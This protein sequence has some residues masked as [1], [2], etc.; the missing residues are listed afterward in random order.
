[1]L[2]KC[3]GG[4]AG[5]AMVGPLIVWGGLNAIGFTAG[6]VAAGTRQNTGIHSFTYT[7]T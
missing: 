2:L 4:I 6:G 1:M 3:A 5:A 7:C